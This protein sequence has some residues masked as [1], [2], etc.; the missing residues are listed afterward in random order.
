MTR[1]WRGRNPYH[2]LGLLLVIALINLLFLFR[3]SSLPLQKSRQIRLLIGIVTPWDTIERRHLIRHLYPLSLQNQ[4]E[5]CPFP[6][7]VRTVFVIC[8][9]KSETAK[10]VLQWESDVFGD[11]MIL[12]GVDE[13]MNEGKTYNFFKALHDWDILGQD[14]G[15]T[16]VGKV[17]DDTWYLVFQKYG[18]DQLRLV[19]PNILTTLHELYPYNEVYYGREVVLEPPFNF[20]YHT[21][22]A[23]FLSA[24]LVRWIATSS[25]P[26]EMFRGHED[27]LVAEWFIK[28][29]WKDSLRRWVSDGEFIDCPRHRG[30]WAARYSPHT[31][32]IHQLKGLEDFVQAAQWFMDA[33]SR[34]TISSRLA[35][36]EWDFPD[37]RVLVP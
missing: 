15:W 5:S 36:D 33:K 9:P 10:S 31:R 6:D 17:D 8:E 28:A 22:M 13:N 4:S 20:A 11:L 24:D 12:N 1:P 26:A 27:H 3:K 29:G 19:L 32:A 14:G 37:E 30:T 7:V 16:H 25:I 2:I 21:G 34:A 18:T 35:S 23:Y